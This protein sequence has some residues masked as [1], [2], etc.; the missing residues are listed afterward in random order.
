MNRS[1]FRFIERLR[2]RWAEIDAQQIVFNG[3]YL[4]YVDTALA[5]YWRALALPYA[6]SMQSL[7]GDL[8]VRKATL[9]Y[10]ASARYDEQLQ[11]GVRCARVGTASVTFAAAVFRDAQRLVH[12]E[13][14]YVFA[15]PATMRSQPVPSPL[16][17]VFDDFEAG[18]PVLT[19]EQGGWD[20]LQAPVLALRRFVFV[21]GLGMV[22]EHLTDGT[23]AASLHAVARN[24]LG[25]VV[26]SGRLAPS[27]E[28]VSRIGRMATLAAVR[29]AGHGRVL[30]DTLLAAA[31]ARGDHEVTLHAH[32]D[33]ASFYGR[34]GFVASGPGFEEAGQPHLPMRR[35]L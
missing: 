17:A 7:Q 16:R 27:A 18:K 23:D 15:D 2:V 1:D 8:Y 31:R 32:A 24:G 3:H 26:G 20:L 29:G 6:A 25:V 4:M 10:E 30:L 5:G 11:I 34:A 21:D 14:V 13:L 28:G 33:A 22:V 19:V 9:E 12:G 35:L